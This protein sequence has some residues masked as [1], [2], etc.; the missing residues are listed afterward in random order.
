MF[1]KGE[2]REGKKE[3]HAACFTSLC[4]TLLLVMRRM[5]ALWLMCGPVAQRIR[6]LT[7]DQG[8]PGSNPGRVAFFF[9][10]TIVGQPCP[11][12]FSISFE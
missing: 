2:G 7:T 11:N 9:L 4:G 8:I 3:I 5:F 10:L 1:E 12:V 6:H